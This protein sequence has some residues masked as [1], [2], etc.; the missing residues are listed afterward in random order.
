[1]RL[2]LISS[3]LFLFSCSNREAVPTDSFIHVKVEISEPIAKSHYLVPPS[4]E[5]YDPIWKNPP[6]TAVFPIGEIDV[7]QID[8]RYRRQ[9]LQKRTL[10]RAHHMYSCEERVFVIVHPYVFELPEEPEVKDVHVTTFQ[11]NTMS[12]TYKGETYGAFDKV[13]PEKFESDF[14]KEKILR[15]PNLKSDYLG[16]GPNI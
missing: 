3:L 1:M 16:K 14:S 6:F 5:I 12:I 13:Y 7:W 10:L 8:G 4:N 9:S 11:D 15:E 2:L